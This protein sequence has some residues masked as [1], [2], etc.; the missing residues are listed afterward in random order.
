MHISN[1]YYHLPPII[2]EKDPVE[3]AVMVVEAM[4]V[5]QEMQPL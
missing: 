2:V 3:A 5:V 1:S 4:E